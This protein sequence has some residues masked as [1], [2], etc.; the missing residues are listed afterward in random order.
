MAYSDRRRRV[1]P[2]DE[3]A[4]RRL[5]GY[6]AQQREAGLPSEAYEAEVSR[7]LEHGLEAAESVEDRTITT[8]ARTE[9]QHFSDRG[10]FLRFPYLEDVREVRNYEVAVLGAPIDAGDTYRTGSRFGPQAIRRISGLYGSYTFEWGVD[11]KESLK[12]LV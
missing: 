5:E 9:E 11:L 4:L 12:R 6:E 2:P 8:F 1:G 10:T 7:A 3:E